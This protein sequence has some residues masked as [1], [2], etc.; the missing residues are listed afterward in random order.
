MEAAFA[1]MGVS[2][3]WRG[4]SVEEKGFV[5]GVSGAGGGA[6]SG[7][8]GLEARVNVGNMVVAVDNSRVPR[9]RTGTE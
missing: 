8:D 9:L 3:E 2:L 1:R 4:S 6:G 5:A 7:A